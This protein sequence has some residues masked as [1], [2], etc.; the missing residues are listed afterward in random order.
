MRLSLEKL[1]QWQGMN[2]IVEIK[3]NTDKYRVS[4]SVIFIKYCGT[5]EA[6]CYPVSIIPFAVQRLP[7]LGKLQQALRSTREKLVSSGNLTRV[8]SRKILVYR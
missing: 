3:R 6:S 1:Y 5:D 2:D 7:K 8:S 4:L